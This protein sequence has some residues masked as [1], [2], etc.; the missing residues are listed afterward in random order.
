MWDAVRADAQ[1]YFEYVGGPS[2]TTV[3][4]Y[5]RSQATW[6]LLELRF[7][8]WLHSGCPRPLSL[9]L[10]PLSFALQ[11]L[12]EVTTGISIEH[13]ARIGRGFYIGHFGGIIIGGGVTIGDRCNI[14]QGVTIGVAGRGDRRGSPTI[15]DGVYIGP[16]A[17]L[18]G[19]ITVGDGA[20]IGANAVVSK[21]VPPGATA[22]APPAELI[23]EES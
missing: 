22:R 10:R 4:Y 12:V 15:G 2:P 18:F 23:V 19:A 20:R 21:D 17:K 3:A 16:G 8:Q 5:L 6:A 1:R 9:A 14:S 7:Y 11:L 13:G